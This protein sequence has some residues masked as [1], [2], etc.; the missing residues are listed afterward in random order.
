MTIPTQA[1]VGWTATIGLVPGYGHG[2]AGVD[3]AERRRLL[4]EQ[5]FASMRRTHDETDL[6]IS[7][8]LS[9]SVVLYPHN[10]CPDGGEVAMTLTGS[11]NPTHVAPERLDDFMAAVE[12]TVRRVQE[13]ME[14]RTVRLEFHRIERSIYSR[15]DD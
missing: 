12:T 8:V 1:A 3:L 10:S 5:W 11:S 2:N 14:Q 15:L 4:V 6:V 7:A 13:A 9:E